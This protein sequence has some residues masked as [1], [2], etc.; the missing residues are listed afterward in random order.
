MFMG[1]YMVL[2]RFIMLY[3]PSP[4][5]NG[6]G[7]CRHDIPIDH[8]WWLLTSLKR[9]IQQW[10]IPPC[11]FWFQHGYWWFICPWSN[12]TMKR[13]M[14]SF[15]SEYVTPNANLRRYKNAPLSRRVGS[16]IKSCVQLQPLKLMDSSCP[17]WSRTIHPPDQWWDH[18]AAF[19]HAARW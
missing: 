9:H 16:Q 6:P 15:V 8:A 3:Q 1:F 11:V 13:W 12:H 17:G 19:V 18:Q 10:F 7:F 4:S 2:S 5:P 14:T